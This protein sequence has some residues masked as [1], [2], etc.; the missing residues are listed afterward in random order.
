MENKD[1]RHICLKPLADEINAYYDTDNGKDVPRG[2]PF[3]ELPE[4]L[5]RRVTEA[6]YPLKWDELVAENRIKLAR[7]HDSTEDDEMLMHLEGIQRGLA[8]YRKHPAVSPE[9]A[10]LLLCGANPARDGVPSDIEAYKILLSLFRGCREQ[11]TLEGWLALAEE[12]EQKHHPMVRQYLTYVSIQA[13]DAIGL[14]Q[15]ESAN[16]ETET[17]P[18][19]LS[20]VQG[21]APAELLI[22][23]PE[24]ADVEIESQTELDGQL[25]TGTN[26]TLYKPKR[27]VGYTAP[28]YRLLH[29]A[30][31]AGMPRPTARNALEAWRT[32]KPQGIVQVMHDGINYE[33]GDGDTK[34]TTIAGIT[35]AIRRMTTRRGN[36]R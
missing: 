32:D 22:A 33:D 23:S 24:Q 13:S 5:R 14:P 4:D 31:Q 2:T 11:K 30:H 9:D 35:E 16:V 18:E 25:P 3:A 34:A 29:N 6:F 7:Q 26:W 15:E 17:A 19:P 8:S 28:L 12:K 1:S 27:Y 20:D 21:E 36:P 10:A